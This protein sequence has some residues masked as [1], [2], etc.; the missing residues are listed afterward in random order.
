MSKT[1]SVT[2]IDP[3]KVKAVASAIQLE[4]RPRAKELGGS[5][6]P[7]FNQD[8]VESVLSS[9]R[10]YPGEDE[11]RL[12]YYAT[13]AALSGIDPRDEIEGML[14]A[15]LIATHNV[16]MECLRLAMIPNQPLPAID[17]VLGHATK[18]SR[19]FA[20][21][22][23]ALNRK[24]GNVQQKVTV[25]HV[26]VQAGGQA[27]VGVIEGGG[28]RSDNAKQPHAKGIAHAPQRAMRSCDEKKEA[29]L[30]PSDAKRPMSD[31]RRSL[32]RGTKRK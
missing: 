21:L 19:T 20:T 17:Q 6:I 13:A 24:R 5:D 8:I 28:G 11:A 31:A 25:E 30:I 18:L 27:I 23:D 1:K 12:R 7:L 15:Q 2:K 10:I 9:R 26:H 4:R 32:N 3:A 14:A 16:A 29:L 22:L